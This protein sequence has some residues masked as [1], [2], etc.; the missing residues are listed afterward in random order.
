M[1]AKFAAFLRG[2]RDGAVEPVSSFLVQR[3]E[4]LLEFLQQRAKQ[5]NARKPLTIASKSGIQSPNRISKG[6]ANSPVKPVLKGK[7]EPKSGVSGESGKKPEGPSSKSPK[8][9][10]GKEFGD[11][12]GEVTKDPEGP[13]CKAPKTSPGKDSGDITGKS[14][15]KSPKKSPGKGSGDASGKSPPRS[16]KK[17]PP[18]ASWEKKNG[19]DKKGTGR[20]IIPQGVTS[21]RIS[22]TWPQTLGAK[23]PLG[24][25][26]SGNDCFQNSMLQCLLHTPAVYSLLGQIHHDCAKSSDRCLVCALQK[27]FQDYW[28]PIRPI[29]SSTLMRIEFRK[30]LLANIPKRGHDLS[31]WHLSRQDDP[32]LLLRFLLQHLEEVA[33]SK[34]SEVFEGHIRRSWKCKHCFTLHQFEQ[35]EMGVVLNIQQPERNLNMER[36]LK[37]AYVE[38]LQLKCDSEACKRRRHLRLDMEHVQTHQF[39]RVPEVLVVQLNRFA[40]PQTKEGKHKLVGGV[41]KE[42]KIKDDVP[43]PEYLDLQPYCEGEQVALYRLDGI[44][45]HMGDQT[46]S[47][48]YVA[49]VRDVSGDGFFSVN[50]SRVKATNFQA[51]ET[52][53]PEDYGDPYILI[54]SKQ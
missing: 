44:V 30:A 54:Y 3:E 40:V 34:T 14:P 42:V 15:P 50:D 36:Y 24:F 9:S 51:L 37:E 22:R 20:A 45:L 21:G 29:R 46:T 2:L 39:L 31:Q 32:L 38:R 5:R 49:G 27:L 52:G 19:R 16:P 53:Y 10:P 18:G 11:G 4:N 25:N 47:G 7:P 43:I 28:N 23:R 48:H 12:S 13:I 17:P 6:K 1:F 33:K 26:N 41:L 35:T 8:K